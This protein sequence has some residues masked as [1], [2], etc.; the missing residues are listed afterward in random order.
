MRCC[1]EREEREGESRGRSKRER[2]E[3]KKDVE[4]RRVPNNNKVRVRSEE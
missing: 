4:K 2:I 3:K 1:K